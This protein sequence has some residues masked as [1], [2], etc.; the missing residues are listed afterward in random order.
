[1][2]LF[3]GIIGKNYEIKGLY[4]EEGITRRLQAL[5]LNDGTVITVLN[6]KKNGALIIRVRGTRLAVGKHISQGIEVE[7]DVQ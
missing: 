6:R 7:E 3:D 4:V 2:S 5:G 1:M